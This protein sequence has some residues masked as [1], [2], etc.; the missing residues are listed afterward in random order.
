MFRFLKNEKL[1]DIAECLLGSEL[2]CNPIQHLRAKLPPLRHDEQVKFAASVPW[3]QDAGVTWEESD[4]S[5]ILTFWIPLVD[6]MAETG[7]MEVIPRAFTR[8]YLTHQ[9]EGG[10]MIVEEQM[11]EN[12]PVVAACPK[13]SIVIMNK[14]TPHRGTTNTSDI[15]RWS[16]DLRY[17][18]TGAHSGRPFH[19]EFIVRSRQNPELVSVDHEQW[20]SMWVDSLA[21]SKGMKAHRV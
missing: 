7:C 1:L 9:K 6:A 14:Y 5:E 19:P 21:N 17:H 3:H 10:T 20:C 13:G 8:G 2:S 16:M 4:A 15:I 18:K 11:P 12:E